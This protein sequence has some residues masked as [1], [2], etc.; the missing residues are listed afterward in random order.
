[1]GAAGYQKAKEAMAKA[2]ARRDMNQRGPFRFWMENGEEPVEVIVLDKTVDDFFYMY[3]HEKFAGKQGR[4]HVVCLQ[5]DGRCPLCIAAENADKNDRDAWKFA[6]YAMYFTVI[7]TRGYT[8]KD[9]KEVPFS[10][11]LMCVKQSQLERFYKVMAASEKKNGTLR[12]T[13]LLL[14]RDGEMSPRTGEPELFEETG[15]LFDF[16][17]E[18]QLLRDY[19]TPA[20]KKDGK[21]VKE[22]DADLKPF[23]YKAEF[24]K[25]TPAQLAKAWDLPLP[26]GSDA[27]LEEE[28]DEDEEDTKPKRGRV[29]TKAKAEPTRG[30]RRPVEDD[31]EDEAEDEVEEEV[32]EDEEEAPPPRGRRTRNSPQAKAE[33]AEE[34]DEEDADDADEEPEEEED[35]PPPRGRAR[36]PAKAPARP[37][38][39]RAVKGKTPARGTRSRTV[40]EDEDDDAIPF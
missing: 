3:E 11:R 4:H 20:I 28:W 37:E 18:K 24:R 26:A 36:T 32:E 27:A 10:R 12:G 7:D 29:K 16:V 34:E 9:G 30:R 22:K 38:R 19:T 2:E 5:D 14:G 21:V 25:F 13:V 39:G 23:D 33:E 15:T 8:N 40:V 35:E 1:M 31:V 6:Y 17:S